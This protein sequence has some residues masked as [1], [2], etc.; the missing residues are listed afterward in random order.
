MLR[1][2]KHNFA[3]RA[4]GRTFF[5]TSP[6]S[7][8][9]VIRWTAGRTALTGEPVGVVRNIHFVRRRW[10]RGRGKN[11]LPAPR[12]SSSFFLNP[13]R[14]EEG[15]ASR[16]WGEVVGGEPEGGAEEVR[17]E[18]GGVEEFGDGLARERGLGDFFE[19]DAGAGGFAEGDGD[20]VPRL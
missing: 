3:S 5:S 12:S 16:E 20:D 10:K 8:Q 6:D 18:G 4:C 1:F 19:D 14:E 7:V 15:G 9:N 17:G 13:Y 2:V 11:I